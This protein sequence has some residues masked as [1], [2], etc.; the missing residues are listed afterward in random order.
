MWCFSGRAVRVY[1]TYLQVVRRGVAKC[2][3]VAA[4][5]AER[6]AWVLAR[7]A[8][9]VLRMSR[10]HVAHACR[11]QRSNAQWSSQ[12]LLGSWATT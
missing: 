12:R 8:P 3:A 9:R 5:N 6:V 7:R 2:C 4:W 10:T 1:Y 11:A